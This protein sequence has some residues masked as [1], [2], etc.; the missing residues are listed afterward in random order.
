MSKRPEKGTEFIIKISGIELPNDV[1]ER[2]AGELRATLMR[3]LAK[4]DTG[5]GKTAAKSAL[6][7]AGGVGGSAFLI[8]RGW[9]GG[10]YIQGGPGG[11]VLKDVVARFDQVRFEAKEVGL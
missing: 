9:N 6:T 4:T 10:W 7:A 5:G 3:E 1:R 2:V 11:P 8:P